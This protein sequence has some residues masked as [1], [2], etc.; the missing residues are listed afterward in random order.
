[1]AAM[2]ASYI[3]RSL[4][5]PEPPPIAR[6]GSF[7]LMRARLFDRPANAALTVICCVI[8]VL[9]GWPAIRFL[10]IDAVWGEQA[11]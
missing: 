9:L 6:R 7:A 2:Q 8:V 3:R 11:G 5:E 10:F 1:M 4:A